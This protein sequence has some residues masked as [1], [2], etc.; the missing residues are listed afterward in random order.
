MILLY[1]LAIVVIPDF[2]K[3]LLTRDPCFPCVF[4]HGSVRNSLLPLSGGGARRS[5]RAVL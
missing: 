5:P 2:L 1:L 3:P 4:D